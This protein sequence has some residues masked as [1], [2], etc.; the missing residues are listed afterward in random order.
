MSKVVSLG[1]SLLLDHRNVEPIVPY[2]SVA[3]NGFSLAMSL[4][5]KKHFKPACSFPVAIP[6]GGR[7]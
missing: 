1:E 3:R 7:A 6:C 2:S 5:G 4:Q